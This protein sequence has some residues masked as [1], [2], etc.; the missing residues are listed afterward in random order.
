MHD[1]G[2]KFG[3]YS[4]AGTKTCAGRAG[5]LGYE[6]QDANDYASWGVDY[7]KYDNC[8]NMGV[9]AT[10]RYMN[11]GNAIKASGRE[12]FYSLCNWG[13]ENVTDW[14]YQTSNS[15]RTTQDIS[16]GNN[17]W[18]SMKSNFLKNLDS[19]SMAGPGHWNDPDMLQ[20]GTGLF[21]YIEEQT[22]FSLWAFSKAPLIIGADLRNMEAGSSS[23]LVLTNS[24]VIGINQDDIGNQCQEVP[25]LRQGDVS[26]YSS[27]VVTNGEPWIAV[28]WVNWSTDQ[29]PEVSIDL[30]AA[31]IADHTYDSCKVYDIYTHSTE[32]TTAGEF[33]KVGAM[34]GHQ[35]LGKKFQCMPFDQ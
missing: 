13:N 20:V 10:T 4:S 19:A 9:N 11:M 2:L 34:Q 18:Q 25:A 33:N 12:M 28:L 32:Q 24:D 27:R 8:Y 6:V 29:S 7:L 16:L 35:S 21:S 5:S 23:H 15:W 30:I 31:G 1:K 3:L 26:A 22:H 14:G 17:A